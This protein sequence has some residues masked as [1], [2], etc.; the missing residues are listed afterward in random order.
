[1]SLM[2]LQSGKSYASESYAASIFGVWLL[3]DS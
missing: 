1:M 3:L 2:L